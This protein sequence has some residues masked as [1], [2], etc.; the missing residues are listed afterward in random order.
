MNQLRDATSPYLL[1]HADN[2]VHWYEWTEAALELAREQ[3]KPILLSIGY[4]ACHW[5]HVMAHESFEDSRTAAVMNDLFVNIK[6]D[7]EERPDLDKIY[8]LAHQALTRQGGGWPLT[9]F[10]TPDDHLPFFGGTY[11]PPTPRH[12]LP[13]F[14]DLLRQVSQ[15]WREQRE[16]IR[17]QNQSLQAF[18]D[19][20]AQSCPGNPNLEVA[21]R[22]E[23]QAAAQFDFEHGGLG[24]APKFP[25]A[26]ILRLLLQRGRQGSEQSLQMALLTLKQMARGGIN[27]Q[28][29]GGFCRYSVDPLW[30]IPHFEKML[31]DNAQLL[32]L[33]VEAAQIDRDRVWA[34]TASRTADWML[35][36]LKA[37]GGAFWSSYDADS[38]GEEG[39]FYV[40][41]RD[42]VQRLLTAEEYAVV[43][44]LWGLDGPANFEGQAWH[45]H[46]HSTLAQVADHLAMD[47]AAAA[48]LLQ[49]A[50]EK[51]L[52]QRA[53]RVAPGLDDKVLTA[54]NGLAIGAL[55]RAGRILERNDFTKAAQRATDYL[56]EN[57]WRDG[58]LLATSRHGH[59]R[60][61]ANLD[62]YA[63]LLDGLTEL[64]QAHWRQCDLEFALALSER[65]IDDFQDV[66]S[67]GFYFVA[68]DHE[69]LI[70]RAKPIQD[71]AIPAGAALA[72]D[73]L[74]CL[75][76]L[77]AKVD[78]LTV[79]ERTIKASWGDIEG[80]PL[81][82]SSALLAAESWLKPGEQ[83]VIRADSIPGKR[84]GGGR[85]F[86]IPLDDCSPASEAYPIKGNFTA[87]R[88]I[89]THCDAPVTSVEELNRLLV[90]SH[91]E[92]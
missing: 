85:C 17:T 61:N 22:A 27:D 67:G 50:R 87:Y 37:E 49:S 20:V 84:P 14:V 4:S 69:P 12:G 23:E 16:A 42:E 72:V 11:F 59:A 64:L 89:G 33:Y 45:L 60:L 88:C 36:H 7:R 38:E 78:F 81:G 86:I 24:R 65:L 70:Q 63:F 25:N 83:W 19:Q 52:A 28:L 66:S 73:G 71:D 34:T 35:A 21:N 56:R 2:P 68:H 30:M 48:R 54:W 31:Y 57:H 6:V 5:C 53:S 90:G 26:P 92:P 40:W 80:S 29:S 10:L 76:H 41:Q 47:R 58:R 1:Q 82:Y 9:M 32:T 15:A 39:K 13:A 46:R 77:L 75:G 18:L 79:A 43:S 62:D 55:A 44:P 3:G 51:L 91:D 74:L 8:Q